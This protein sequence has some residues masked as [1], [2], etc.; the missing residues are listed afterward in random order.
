MALKWCRSFPSFIFGFSIFVLPSTDAQTPMAVAE[1]AFPSTVMIVM[2]DSN[3][4]PNTIGSGFVVGDGYVASNF[5]VVEGASRG[6]VKRIGDKMKY[7]SDGVAAL[8]Q[9]SD[10]VVLKVRGLNAPKL[11]V[12]DS[13]Q[14]SVG[15]Q[16]FAVG[17]PQG[18]EGTFSQGIVSSIRE[19]D[20]GKLLQITAPISP[21]SSG[22]PILNDAAQVVG[23][24]VATYRGGQNLNFAIPASRLATL[25][26]KDLKVRSLSE[27]SRRTSTNS[28]LA[29]LS[30]R[31]TEGIVVRKF[32]WP[33]TVWTT[34]RFSVL[35]QLRQPVRN[36]QFLVIFFDDEQKPTN[37]K[38]V[39]IK[40]T[41]PGGLATWIDYQSA[42]V[43]TAAICNIEWRKKTY[44]NDRGSGSVEVR[45]LGF[46]LVDEPG[47]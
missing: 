26:S 29:S 20:G 22:G 2:E 35:N 10:L 11:G 39:S 42:D 8:D 44:G 7:E 5:H 40:K 33:T 25:L 14:L 23:V 46:E 41:L 32:D 6:F 16:V 36:P 15:Q 12:A 9:F 45:I 1:K 24:T 21:G 37:F 47:Y 3:G 18:L 43:D 27:S 17:N 30:G 28:I 34:F 38:L 13:D 19:T 31:I 4:Q